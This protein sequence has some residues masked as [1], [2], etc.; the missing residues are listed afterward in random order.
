MHDKEPFHKRSRS[1]DEMNAASLAHMQAREMQDLVRNAAGD[2]QMGERIKAQINRAWENLG[3]PKAWRVRAAWN[4]EAGCWSGVACLEF[5]ERYRVYREQQ[6]TRARARSAAALTIIE[7]I[8]ADNPNLDRRT[9][10]L[11]RRAHAA[12]GGVDRTVA[13][14]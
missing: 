7:A 8:D 11:L 6:E 14:R 4:G 13:P 10:D 1:G 3:R 12:L 2:P 5:K 9:A